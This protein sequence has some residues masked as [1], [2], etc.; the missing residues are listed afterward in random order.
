[1]KALC[2]VCALAL[3]GPLS[4]GP[5]VINLSA[6]QRT[7]GSMKVDIYYDVLNEYPMTVTLDVSADNGT[8]WGYPCTL[9]TGDVGPN[10]SPGVGKH[11]VWDVLTEHPNMSGPL[12]KFKITADDGYPSGF[13]FVQGGY[14]HNGSSWVT[15][16]SF[17]IDCFELTQSQYQAVMGAN[18][19][20]G[21]GVGADYPVYYVS[22]FKAVEYCNRR[23]IAEGIPPCYTYG[24]YGTNPAN[25]PAGW[26]SVSANQANI[27]CNFAVRGYR[28]P[29]VNEWHFAAKGGI[30]SHNYNYSGSNTLSLVGWYNDNSGNHTHPVGTKAANELGIFDMSGNEAEWCWD[31]TSGVNR[32]QRGGAFDDS[33]QYCAVFAI[34]MNEPTVS[35]HWCGFRLCRSF[36]FE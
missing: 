3:A 12:F 33:S 7:D 34:T 18:P 19:A 30:F 23:S 36:L 35:V 26:N 27:S 32:Q 14:W 11:I 13:V 1:M 4:A 21:Y 29:T 24:T 25:W 28:L 17:Y 22:W 31:L 16:P 5:A 15:T 20:T 2:C 10:I 8:T 6:S 9:V